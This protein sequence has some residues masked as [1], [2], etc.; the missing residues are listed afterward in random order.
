MITAPLLASPLT[1]LERSPLGNAIG[2][3]VDFLSPDRFA[4]PMDDQTEVPV[5]PYL[6]RLLADTTGDGKPVSPWMAMLPLVT[7]F[8]VG[9]A[10][11]RP[12][13][14]LRLI[15]TVARELQLR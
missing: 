5:T 8:D 6:R 7:G 2:V 1:P 13:P 15:L 14:R 3:G 10:A 4:D 9:V 11:F 12:A